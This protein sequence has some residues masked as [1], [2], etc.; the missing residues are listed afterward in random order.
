VGYLF[1]RQSDWENRAF[2]DATFDS[3]VSAEILI[4]AADY[5]EL[6]ETALTKLAEPLQ[7][8]LAASAS[9]LPSTGGPFRTFQSIGVDAPE[10]LPNPNL[11]A[12]SVDAIRLAGPLTALEWFSWF[13]VFVR[14]TSD[15]GLRHYGAPGLQ[16]AGPFTHDRIDPYLET[17]LLAADLTTRKTQIAIDGS[18]LLETTSTGTQ[19]LIVETAK[20]LA[21]TRPNSDIRVIALESAH[22]SLRTFFQ[23]IPNVRWGTK[24]SFGSSKADV[25]YRPYQFY[26]A[27]ELHWCL[28]HGHRLVISQLDMIAFN[29][30]SYYPRLSLF[31]EI[32]NVIRASLGSADALTFISEFGLHAARS[33]VGEIVE[34]GRSHIVPCGTD[35]V[36]PTAF[37]EESQISGPYIFCLAGSFSHKNRPFAYRVFERM[38]SMGYTGSLV[39]AGPNPHY[40]T[41]AELQQSVLKMVSADTL[42]AVRD[43]GIVSESAKWDLLRGADAV[44]YPSVIEGFG[45]VPFEAAQVGS[46]TLS[47]RSTA[48]QEL[49]GDANLAATWDPDQ[50]A[51]QIMEWIREP[52]LAHDQVSAIRRAG[53]DL[54][55][56]SSAE[57]LWQV[58]DTTLSCPKRNPSVGSV[59]GD[60]FVR[61]PK[62]S[63]QPTLQLTAVRFSRRA[64]SFVR[65]KIRR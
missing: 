27:K 45:L 47:H 25:V 46:P 60:A 41:A 39:F 7:K 48:F 20:A 54:T 13:E 2:I 38:R 65:R 29:N 17:H 8:D 63:F 33:Q 24:Q 43:L 10:T 23:G 50:W 34:L 40:G 4:I 56:E 21:T 53:A 9:P 26:T 3:S 14:R 31:H 58:F 1:I 37:P 51:T 59:E 32:R 30:E 6:P 44:L 62:I 52:S 64:L 12:L 61:Y 35:H 19:R 49:L 18:C 5:L 16:M 42:H 57:K 28:E 36:N 55:W 15:L 11:V 22:E